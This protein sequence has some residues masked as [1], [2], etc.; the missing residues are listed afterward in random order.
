[1]ALLKPNYLKAVKKWVKKKKDFGK[2]PTRRRRDLIEDYAYAIIT[3]QKGY[4]ISIKATE[5]ISNSFKKLQ[6]SAE[7]LTKAIRQVSCEIQ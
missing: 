5:E 3:K 4:G 1:M 7:E 6:K 2:Y